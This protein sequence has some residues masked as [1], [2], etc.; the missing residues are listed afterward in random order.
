MHSC[1]PCSPGVSI[2]PGLEPALAVTT[3]GPQV[4]QDDS[5][6]HLRP[7]ASSPRRRS[8]VCTSTFSARSATPGP[9]PHGPEGTLVRRARRRRHAGV[10]AP[11]GRSHHLRWRFQ[12]RSLVL[13]EAPLAEME[14]LARLL[15]EAILQWG[16]AAL[17]GSPATTTHGTSRSRCARSPAAHPPAASWP[18]PSSLMRAATRSSSTRSCFTRSRDEQIETLIHELGHVFGLRHS[19]L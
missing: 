5:P 7:R 10:R 6:S 4:P 19:S 17:S 3:R 12:P 14:A 11:V 8:P 16:P 9:G 18:A 2:E 13:F 15:G 1:H